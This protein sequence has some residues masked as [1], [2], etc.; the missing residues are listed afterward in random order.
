MTCTERRNNM[1]GEALPYGNG[2]WS[3][4]RLDTYASSG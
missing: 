4:H 2:S 1:A 3:C